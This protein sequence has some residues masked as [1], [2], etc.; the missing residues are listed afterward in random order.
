LVARLRERRWH[1][2][3]CL[4]LANMLA[5]LE[6]VEEGE[7]EPLPAGVHRVV[8]VAPRDAGEIDL[9]AASAAN[10]TLQSLR[11][12]YQIDARRVFRHRSYWLEREARAF[13]M[14]TDQAYQCGSAVVVWL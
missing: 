14:K 8:T 9:P 12:P 10:L 2:L 3:P 1:Y 11:M 6:F 5:E 13:P 7:A 4:G